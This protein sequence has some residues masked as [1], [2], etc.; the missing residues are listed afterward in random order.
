MKN[1]QSGV[2]K[3]AA[4]DLTK[5]A[6]ILRPD[7]RPTEALKVAMKFYVEAVLFL[8]E[9]PFDSEDDLIREFSSEE[10]H[11]AQRAKALEQVLQ[12]LREDTLELDPKKDDDEARQ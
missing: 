6:A 3:P 1:K 4:M 8:R 7:L 5:L 12:A 2:P 11:M 9:L 10:R